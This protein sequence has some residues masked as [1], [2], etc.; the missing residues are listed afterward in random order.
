MAKKACLIKKIPKI[1]DDHTWLLN[2]NASGDRGQTKHQDGIGGVKAGSGKSA[3][4]SSSGLPEGWEE[5]KT[6]EGRVYYVDHNCKQT[7]IKAA[8]HLNWRNKGPHL[9]L[10]VLNG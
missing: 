4:D 7:K 10:P 1:C 8:F 6:E 2:S 9:Q 3:R 5:R